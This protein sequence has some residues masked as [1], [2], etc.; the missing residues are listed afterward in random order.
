MA[1]E[2]PRREPWPLALAAA[3]LASIAV[4][5]AFFAIAVAYP[6]RPALEPG[7]PRPAEGWVA[8]ADAAG[9]RR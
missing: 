3:L 9:A 5:L 1:A 8:P 7:D 4:C 6:D 2:R